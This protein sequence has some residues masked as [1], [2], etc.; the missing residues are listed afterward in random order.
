METK[1]YIGQNFG[2]E[3][4]SCEY[5]EVCLQDLQLYFSL[6]NIMDLIYG[7]SMFDD[8]LFNDM[9]CMTIRN[10]INKYVP[11]YCGNF[12]K[13]GIAGTLY[14]GVDDMGIVDG[15]PFYGN[16]D[17]DS[18]KQIVQSTMV[19]CRGI[20]CLNDEYMYDQDVV[21]WYYDHMKIE[22]HRLGY[23]EYNHELEHRVS[24][25]R[26]RRL[27]DINGRTM[28]QWDIFIRENNMWQ[29]KRIKY[30]GKLVNYLIDDDMRKDLIKYVIDEFEAHPSYDRKQLENMLKFYSHNINYYKQLRFT[31]D[32][33]E[34]FFN[35]FYSPVRWLINYKDSILTKLKKV[36][37]I[38]PIERPDI[39]LYLRFCNNIQNIRPYLI[40]TK[41]CDLNF[42]IIKITF[43]ILNNAYLE[44]R[45]TET[46][47]WISRARISLSTGPSCS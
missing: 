22:V 6:Q 30:G 40:Q 26:L 12:S 17:V 24:A 31:L 8:K 23:D 10:Y 13:G 18:I 7:N 9:I 4:I 46:S 34:T 47:Q 2:P 33:I 3:T 44:Y 1:Y 37:P 45:Y 35:D 42:Y 28:R 21:K 39:K 11:K 5:K 15:F 36:K 43:P 38:R 16:I 29:V 20:C 41:N 32:Y 19:N 25:N 14:I 27:E